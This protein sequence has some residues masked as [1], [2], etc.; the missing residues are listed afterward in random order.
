MKCLH[1]GENGGKKWLMMNPGLIMSGE[2][3]SWAIIGLVHNED[4][5]PS[6][7]GTASGELEI[8]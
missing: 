4:W 6:S 1:L 7:V 3:T 2:W 5:K 8:L